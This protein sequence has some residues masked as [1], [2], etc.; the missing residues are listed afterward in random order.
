MAL[1]RNLTMIGLAKKGFDALRKP[2]NQARLKSGVSALRAK[3]RSRST[4]SSR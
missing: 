3:T 1:L 4:K 2:E